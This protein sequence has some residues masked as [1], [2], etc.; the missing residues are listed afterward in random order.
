LTVPFNVAVAA[1]AELAACVVTAG[2]SPVVRV[3]SDPTVVPPSFV[4]T[5]RK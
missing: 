3:R 1:V 4:A 5:S 2:L